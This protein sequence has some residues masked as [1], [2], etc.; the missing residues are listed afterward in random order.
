MTKA[1]I[2]AAFVDMA[3]LRLNLAAERLQWV[4]GLVDRGFS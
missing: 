3:T 2:S 1:S 4:A